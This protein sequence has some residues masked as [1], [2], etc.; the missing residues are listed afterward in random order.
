MRENSQGITLIALIVTIIILIILSTIS[1][2]LL[3]G[4]DGIFKQLYQAKELTKINEYKERIDLILLEEQTK[5]Y[6]E[7]KAMT[8]TGLIDRFESES[9]IA[10][11]ERIDL[12][13]SENKG[14]IRLTT[15]DG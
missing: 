13:E 15:T 4:S 1:I 2:N 9:F 11:A 12:E 3:I 5:K 8:V 10:N 14:V 6:T 7:S